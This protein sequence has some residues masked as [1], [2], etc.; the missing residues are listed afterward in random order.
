MKL[1]QRRKDFL[2]SLINIYTRTA[3]PVHYETLAQEVGVSKWTAYDMLQT[4][5]KTGFLAR[6]YVLPGTGG[7]RS[8]V[9]YTPTEKAYGMIGKTRTDSNVEAS[10]E[11][12][13][14]TFRTWM[15][16]VH[17][18]DIMSEMLEA[19]QT[20]TT[21]VEYCLYALDVLIL[22]LQGTDE[23]GIR[24]IK[25]FVVQAPSGTM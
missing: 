10:V 18:D 16:R 2:N 13:L 5:Q 22:V 19:I 21:K 15:E 23:E 9:V 24:L 3:K 1:T 14:E 6:E 25:H 17:T 12:A 4:L 8:Q 20:T 7:G 11:R